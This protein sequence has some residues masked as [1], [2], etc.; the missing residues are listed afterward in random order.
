[1]KK[2]PTSSKSGNPVAEA[3]QSLDHAHNAVS[4]AQSHP[5]D[6]LV[7]E[8][9]NAIEHAENALARVPESTGASGAVQLAEEELQQEKNN[10]ESLQ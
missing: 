6:K 8:A 4:M 9:G 10:L 3:Q 1:M 5:S 7:R 2:Q